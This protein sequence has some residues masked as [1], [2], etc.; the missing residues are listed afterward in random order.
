MNTI[1]HSE[2]T[3]TAPNGDT[4]YRQSWLPD[5]PPRAIILLVHG[6]SEHS[7]RYMN[8]V[9]HFVPQGFAVYGFDHSGHG[10]STGYRKYIAD[11]GEYI[12]TLAMVSASVRAEYSGVPVFLLGHSMGGL[13]A[14]RYLPQHQQEFSGAIIS[15]PAIKLVGS[16]SPFTIQV[17]KVMSVL[18]PKIGL[19]PLNPYGV[20]RDT[21]VVNA[22]LDDPLIYK[23]KTPAR[24]AAEILKNMDAVLADAERITLPV[25][26]VQGSADIIV[27]PEGAQW[28]HDALGSDD[29]NLQVYDGLYHEVLNEPE[30][31][32]V[33]ADIENWLLTRL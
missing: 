2:T 21:E 31:K 8:V 5:A 32:S 9:N 22:Y 15:A 18:L 28:L 4:I 24:L 6:L 25:L 17:G 10:K 20:S 12:A 26:I 16:L 13:I 14:A 30:H 7:S 33:L 23:G 19:I 3:F 11:F 27:D 29:K 1:T